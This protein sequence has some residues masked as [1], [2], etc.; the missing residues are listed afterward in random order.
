MT[1]TAKT[2]A[3][4]LYDLAKEEG[5]VETVQKD[6]TTVTELMCAQ[7]D[8]LR[9]LSTPSVPKPERRGLLDEALRGSVHLYTLNFLKLLCDHGTISQLSGCTK[10]YR[11]RFNED[12]GIMEV[13]AV[14]AVE[15]PSGLRE[16]LIG[17]LEAVTG[18]KIDLTTRVDAQLLGGVRLELPDRQLDGTVRSHLQQ[19]RRNLRETVL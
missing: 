6:L 19:L 9:L 4:A 13:C 2:Y 18:K 16:K 8:Y 10:R 14:S 5:L 17:K 15:L 11:E 3:D 12:H 1:Q 7:P